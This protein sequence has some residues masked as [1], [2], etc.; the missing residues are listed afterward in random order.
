MRIST[1]RLLLLLPGPGTLALHPSRSVVAQF[2]LLLFACK[3]ATFILTSLVVVS[4]L[5][6]WRTIFVAST[7]IAGL[8]VVSSRTPLCSIV[9][10]NRSRDRQ[11][12]NGGSSTSSSG[13]ARSRR[14]LVPE[15]ISGW[16]AAAAQP[17]TQ[18]A[19]WNTPA[20]SLCFYRC[21]GWL[22]R[23]VWLLLIL[24]LLHSCG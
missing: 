15:N 12:C 3:L 8:A 20:R 6:S 11:S 16:M 4:G 7:Q 22:A 13:I 19:R 2:D 10:V 14:Q 1:L 21:D 24:L 18:L 5:L 17:R 9:V 23:P